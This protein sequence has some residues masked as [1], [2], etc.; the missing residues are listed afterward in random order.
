M[1]LLYN[2]NFNTMKQITLN[3]EDAKFKFFMELIKSLDFVQIEEDNGDSKEEILA[4][5]S[6]AIEE[7]KLI[8]QGKLKGKPF[9]E[10]LDEL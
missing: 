1:S 3:I 7:V 4:S 9:N 8:K 2:H 10:L 5:L 6:Q